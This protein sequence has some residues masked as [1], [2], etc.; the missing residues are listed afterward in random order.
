[1]NYHNTI[2]SQAMKKFNESLTLDWNQL[3][4]EQK[5][6]YKDNYDYMSQTIIELA[7]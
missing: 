4:A 5:E 3:P 6:Y 2:S 7:R 1:M